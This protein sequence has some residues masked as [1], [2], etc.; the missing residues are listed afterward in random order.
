MS[1]EALLRARAQDDLVGMKSGP[2]LIDRTRRQILHIVHHEEEYVRAVHSLD[3]LRVGDRRRHTG[4]V[5]GLL[6]G[7]VDVIGR[8]RRHG[9]VREGT[10]QE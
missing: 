4:Y 3:F 10:A 6:D 7:G 9:D 1:P 8:L 5:P 2:S